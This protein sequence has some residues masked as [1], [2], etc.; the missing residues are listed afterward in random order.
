MR[1]GVEPHD[2]L[3]LLLH[4]LDPATRSYT[5]RVFQYRLDDPGHA[6]G[7]LTAVD[8]TS[9][10]VVERDNEQGTAARFKRIFR[11]DLA[12]TDADGFVSKTLVADLLDI[13][14]PRG[15]GGEGTADGVFTFPFVTIEGVLPIDGR[16]L[17]VINDNNFPFS[18]GRT[19]GRPDGTE[20]ILI[21]LDP[22]MDRV[23]T[24]A[25]RPL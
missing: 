11:I 21:G 13:A 20:S 9:F 24:A 4:E 25:F 1:L 3:R 7:D 16:T 18:S 6:I 5:G 8:G 23:R 17:L 22:P 2:H 12:E 14:D 10:L 19:P 15:L